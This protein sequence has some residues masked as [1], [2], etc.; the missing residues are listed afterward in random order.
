MI[1]EDPRQREFLLRSLMAASDPNRGFNF[2]NPDMSPPPISDAPSWEDLDPNEV[3]SAQRGLPIAAL[4][5]QGGPTPEEEA[6]Y[7]GEELTSNGMIPY[8]HK[9]LFGVKGTLRDILGVF[10]DAITGNGRYAQVRRQETMSDALRG[11]NDDPQNSV[12]ELIR[13]GFPAEA[14]K[15]RDDLENREIQR[16]RYQ[17]D[18]ENSKVLAD[19]R[20]ASMARYVI[21]RASRFINNATDAQ[22]Q[23]ALP[24]IQQ[25]LLKYGLTYEAESL[26]GLTP[27]DRKVW[28]I[29]PYKSNRLEDF[30]EDRESRES[31][32][33]MN[34]SGRNARAAQSQN[35]QDARQDKRLEAQDKR[36]GG[37][38]SRAA[39]IKPPPKKGDKPRFR[40]VK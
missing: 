22:F 11:F 20:R 32:A 3:A 13:R 14:I 7:D 25:E 4:Y 35:R 15:L 28:G 5:G 33:G 6:E 23:R 36:P 12:E 8:E 29:D 2:S 18:A 27:E 39:G 24:A 1:V 21:D 9:G 19:S 16:L 10:G 34:E 40:F 38:P 31:I 30:D 26:A 17:N 37:A